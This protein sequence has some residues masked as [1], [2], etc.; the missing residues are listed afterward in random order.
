[1]KIKLLS[2]QPRQRTSVHRIRH[3]EYG[4]HLEENSTVEEYG[5]GR[6]ASDEIARG[7]G[8][9]IINESDD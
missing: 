2:R 8:S 4:E 6:T 3:T 7:E 5:D 1:M 9:Q